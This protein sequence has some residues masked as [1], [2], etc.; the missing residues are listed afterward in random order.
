[1]RQLLVF[2]CLAGWSCV[3]TNVVAQ[4]WTRF[5]GPNGTGVSEATTIPVKWSEADYNWKSAV[6]GNG[7]SSPCVWGDRVFLLSADPETA[8][9]HVLCYSAKDG[10]KLWQRDY[11]SEVHH[12]H[13]R[14]SFA[15][16]SPAVDADHMYVGW[17]TPNETTLKAFDHQ[18]QEVW[19]LNLG[20]W[21]SQ[22]G[23]GASPILYQD[24][25]ILHN[26]QQ[27]KQLNEGELPGLSFMMAFNRLTGEEVWRVPL[28]SENV[29][30]SVPFI[31]QNAKGEDE[32]VCTS[33]GNGVFSLDPRTGNKNWAVEGTFK[34]RTVSSPI[35][36]GGLIF[37]STGSGAYSSNA[38]V[39]V[40]PGPEPKLAY[41]LTNSGQFKAPYV[42]CLIAE[43]DN[44]FCFY[45]KGFAACVHAPTGEVRWLE[46]TN[47]AFSGSPIRV[48]DKLYCIDEEG[49]V[50]VVAADDQE[51]RVLAKNAL[52]EP[53]RSTPAVSG[54]KMFLRTFSHLICVG[55]SEQVAA[56]R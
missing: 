51:Y 14:S 48:R 10:Q 41:E 42:P 39:A 33:T 30:Y 53:S 38:V 20:R 15:S 56:A 27:A 43:G 37:G 31:Y 45:D 1:M 25:V 13:V 2:A 19:S 6:P 52:G 12:L 16:C 47:A 40:R 23:F 36:A 50:W 44:V 35:L 11:A 9:R 54:G 34:M 7:N 8:T 55:G 5:R 4:D 22:H 24:L 21:Q 32:L 46:R 28:V 17:S 29:C 3:S 18:G 49:V 26:S